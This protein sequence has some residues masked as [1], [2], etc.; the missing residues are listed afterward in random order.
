MTFEPARLLGLLFA[1][2]ETQLRELAPASDGDWE[3]LRAECETLG[4]TGL[5]HAALRRT[6]C[7]GLAPQEVADA[8]RL[9]YATNVANNLSLASE[10]ERVLDALRAAGLVA[11]PMKGIALFT[12]RVIEDL[13]TRPT[14]DIDLV[15]R[16]SERA[17]VLSA[18]GR[19]GYEGR[20]EVASWKH[21]PALWRRGILVEVH[22]IAYWSASTRA[23]YGTE[24]LAEDSRPLRLGRL[25]AL[26]LH[27]LLLGSPPDAALVVRTLADVDGFLRIAAREPETRAAIVA[28]AREAGLERALAGC[29][30]LLA[31]ARQATAV[32]DL[33]ATER[34]AEVILAPLRAPPTDHRAAM[35][36]HA[37]RILPVQ[38]WAVTWEMLS[39]LV[40]PPPDLIG[41]RLGH[42]ARSAAVSWARVRRPLELA[43]RVA[44]AIPATLRNRSGRQ[45]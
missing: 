38:P 26:Q 15:T 6:R 23:V 16:S 45:G 8:L 9:A 33:R 25:C 14:G 3:A 35:L 40:F 10:A 1:P 36:L 7:A 39:L 20:N 41:A 2:N 17:A 4:A 19:L 30:A 43:V 13:G 28:A 44:R 24:H 32:L 18:L 12:E 29:D 5:L 31:R 27:H 37:L 11:A 22:E 21:L 42:S 34:E